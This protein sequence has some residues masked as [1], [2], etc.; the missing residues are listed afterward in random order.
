MY[1]RAN[2]HS[3]KV[4]TLTP[5]HTHARLQC[6]CKTLSASFGNSI[7]SSKHQGF[8]RCHLVSMAV[9]LCLSVLWC[10]FAVASTI[11]LADLDYGGVPLWIDRLL[12]EP[13]VLS[14]R[15][16]LDVAWYRANNPQACP[17]QCDCP[18]QWPTALYC[19]HRGLADVPE[20][21]PA[22]TQYLFLQR[23]NISSLT[24]S[25]L[26]NITGLHWLIL[27]HNRLR[28]DQLDQGILQNQ[29]QLVHLFANHNN[30][31]SVPNNLPDGLKQLRLAYNQISS[32][33]PDAFKNLKNLTLLLLQ[34]NI[35]KTIK[36]GEL[37]GLVN[38]NLLDLGGNSFSS[39]PKHLPTYVQQLYL[40]KNPLSGLDE[41]SFL[42]FSNLQ[43]L[44]LSH[45]NLKNGNVH[46]QAFNLS[47][48]VE[49][50]LSYNKFTSIPEVPITLQHLYL[51]ANEIKE[52]N[53]TSFCREVGRLTYSRL[54][55]LRLDGNELSYRHLPSDWV[56]CLRVIQDIFI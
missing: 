10:A 1:S 11:T 36:E 22:R 17:Q 33:G 4:L 31:S 3:M 16:R 25:F 55:S 23:N 47:T 38:L 42:G 29:S 5:Q 18:I 34:G 15:G 21:L 52:F 41:D 26:A 7:I 19:D 39:V 40:S 30:L 51:E 48:L 2:K 27:D 44:R 37:R 56:F 49:L 35:L 8:H 14:L 24:S 46:P 50:D 6:S 53:L 9:L 45:C 28:S 32:I 20:H 54:K 43:Y 12:G 13:S